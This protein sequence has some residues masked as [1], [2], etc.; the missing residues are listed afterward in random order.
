MIAEKI[1]AGEKLTVQDMRD[2]QQDT[3]DVYGRRTVPLM[4]SLIDKVKGDYD[5]EGQK[6]LNDVKMLLT[7][8]DGSMGEDSVAGSVY[9]FH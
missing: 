7:G 6:H 2:I 4:I 3:V 5:E 8:W 9:Q 1:Q